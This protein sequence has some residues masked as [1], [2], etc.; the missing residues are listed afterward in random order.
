M[1]Y[2]RLLPKCSTAVTWKGRLFKKATHSK[3]CKAVENLEWLET[4]EV[5]KEITP[6]VSFNIKHISRYCSEW[7]MIATVADRWLKR[8]TTSFST[9]HW[10]SFFAMVKNGAHWKISAGF[11]GCYTSSL[12]RAIA[13]RSSPTLI[14]C[15]QSSN[16]N[17]VFC[18]HISTFMYIKKTNKAAL[19]VQ[20]IMEKIIWENKEIS[21]VLLITI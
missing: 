2:W 17:G 1:V 12:Q 3:F 19:Y 18:L 15:Q 9:C 4:T 20:T 7:L 10:G 16:R 11:P 6:V 14:Q 5:E 13:F 8:Q 21:E